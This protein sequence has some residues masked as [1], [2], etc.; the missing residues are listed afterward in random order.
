[1]P[2]TTTPAAPWRLPTATPTS[3]HHGHSHDI[4]DPV[5]TPSA[6]QR[7]SH[8]ETIYN[9]I[10]YPGAWVASSNQGR[11]PTASHACEHVPMPDRRHQT[12]KPPFD[13]A[14]SRVRPSRI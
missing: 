1:M 13:L 14:G 11:A 5:P 4:I 10:M 2:T 3:T 7:H 8:S 9:L 12:T 6:R